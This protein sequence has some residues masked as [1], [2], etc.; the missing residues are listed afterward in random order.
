MEIKIVKE[1][2]LL[3]EVQRIAAESFIDMAKAVV[4]IEQ[5]ILAVGGE[6]HADA[7]AM[8]LKEGSV[9]ANLWG[10]NIYPAKSISD[11]I[12]FSSL[13][14]VRPSANNRSMEILDKE[15]REKIAQI[16]NNLIQ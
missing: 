5:K 10:I 1:K 6:W 16:V 7:E 4:D 2:I 13:I 9:Q 11:R 3:S 14:N 12:E 15:I 8:L